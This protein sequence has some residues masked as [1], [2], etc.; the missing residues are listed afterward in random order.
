MAMRRRITVLVLVL[1]VVVVGGLL[2]TFVG[3][4]RDAAARS[5]CV[6]NLKQLG[7]GLETYR[8]TFASFPPGT[9]PNEGLPPERRLAWLVDTLPFMDQIYIPFDRS[10]AWDAAVNREPKVSRID[11]DVD[12]DDV[13]GEVAGLRCPA[14]E[15]RA[16]AG[17]PG[18][19]DYVGI[20]GLGQDAVTRDLGYPGTGV[21]GFDRKT[22]LDDIKDGTANTML[23]IETTRDNGPWTAGGFPTVRGLDPAG[24]PYLGKGGQ[25]SSNHRGGTN[26]GFADGSVRTLN[27][28]VRPEAFEA[29]ATLAGGEEVGRVGEE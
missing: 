24:G 3:R 7:L 6:N 23:V 17:W 1:V 9:V 10:Q 8:D 5:Q 26:V 20:A 13:L 4:V 29:M 14:N 28:T 22:G 25:F 18:L 11:E 12:K 15:A 16:T 21:F 2:V 27:E 19:T